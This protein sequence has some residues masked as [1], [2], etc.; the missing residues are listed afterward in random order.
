MNKLILATSLSLTCALASNAQQGATRANGSASG[1][2][3]ASARK[4]GRTSEIASGTRLAGELQNTIDVRKAAVGDQVILKTTQAIKAQGHIVV[5]KGA[6]LFGHVTEVT[7]KTK[8]NGE[9]RVGVLFDRLESGSLDVPIATSISSIVSGRASARANDQEVL[10][11]NT[12]ASGSTRSTSQRS[13][14]SGQSNSGLLGGVGGVVNGTTSTVGDV[15]G[16]TTTAVGAT[17]DG[18]ANAAGG[19]A[20][21]LGR[22]LSRIQISESSTTNAEGGSVLSLRGDNLRLEKG[23][24]FNLVLTQ[25][26]S[27]SNSPSQ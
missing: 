3:T 9:S 11:A 6:R 21:G 27:L 5:N 20:S 16:S 7:Q 1:D 4:A 22:S 18:T 15:V 10:N 19:T 13:S 14:S 25:S 23:T 17:V 2:V 26:A 24:T 12:S 8:A